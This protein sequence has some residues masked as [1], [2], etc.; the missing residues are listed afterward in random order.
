MVL[1]GRETI[2]RDGRPVGWLTSGGWGYTLATNIGYGYLRDPEPA[3]IWTLAAGDYALEVA[4][5]V[6]PCQL[7][8]QPLYDPKN[9]RVKA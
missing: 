3:S 7:Q 4:C 9:A 1:L 8:L 2:L 5:E 6:V